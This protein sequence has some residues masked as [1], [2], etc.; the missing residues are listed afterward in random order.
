MA[1]TRFLASVLA[2]LLA[3][4]ALAVVL[5][6]ERADVM[7]H[8]YD[9]GGV[10]VD[11]PS[12]L[13]RKN[14]KETVSLSANY[15]VDHVSSASIDVLASGASRYTEERTEYSLGAIYLYDKSTVAAGYTNSDENDYEADTFY[16]NISQDFFGDLTTLNLGYTLGRDDVFQTGNDEFADEIERQHFRV[17][18]SQILTPSM[19]MG[20]DYELITDEGFLNNPYRSY[21]YLTDPLDPASGYQLAQEVYPRTRTSDSAALRLMYYFPGRRTVSANYRFFTDDWGVDAHTAQLGFTQVWREDWTFELRYRYYEQTAADFYADLF[22]FESQD[23]KDWRARD[24]ELSD[25]NNQTLSLYVSY[26]RPLR[27]RLFDR[28][29]LTV[30]WDHIWFDYENFTDLREQVPLP[31]QESTYEFEADVYKV[32]FSLWY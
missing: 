20:L 14:F 2:L 29:E 24:K 13:V 30:Q 11:G 26:A 10:T 31:G 32:I 15:Y 22:E 12:V 27:Y 6:E 16:F 17:G 5:P 4:A 23:D 19:I 21:R 7:Y 8:R 28:A 3:P 25:F 1:A 9:G 18:V